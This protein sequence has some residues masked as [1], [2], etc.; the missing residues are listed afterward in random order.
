M[1]TLVGQCGL[2]FPVEKT[3]PPGEARVGDLWRAMPAEPGPGGP[4]LAVRWGSY[5]LRRR[6]Y[7]VPGIP[8]NGRK[9]VFHGM[10]HGVVPWGDLTLGQG[11]TVNIAVAHFTGCKVYSLKLYF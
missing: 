1:A 6:A 11:W 3:P 10:F 8:T 4:G 9:S 2:T 7:Y 5:L